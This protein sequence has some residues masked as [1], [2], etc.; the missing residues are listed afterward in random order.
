M[1][2]LLQL[3]LIWLAFSLRGRRPV[4]AADPLCRYLT[5]PRW[6]DKKSGHVKPQAFKLRN[7]EST[8]SVYRIGGVR[9]ARVW[10]IG[11]AIA[12]GSREGVLHGRADFRAQDALDLNLGFRLGRIPSLHLEIG[13]GP[14]KA[15]Q[16]H[17]AEQLAAKATLVAEPF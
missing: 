8:L 10:R 5:S 9:L 3:R 13:Y 16:I 11:R 12:S 1:N 17:I 15:E 4:A 2:F 6:L 7:T 14:S